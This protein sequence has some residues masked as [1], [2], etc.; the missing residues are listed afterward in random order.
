MTDEG[1]SAPRAWKRESSREVAGYEMFRVREDR[2]VSPKDG[3]TH[4]FQIAESPGGVVVVAETDDGRLVMVQQFRHGTRQVTLELPSGVADDGESPETAA[5]RE[6][7]EETGYE[8]EGAEVLGAVE[9][10]PS[11]QHTCVHV[12]RVRGARATAEKEPDETEEIRVCL[13][14][15]NELRR[16]IVRGEVDTA[17]TVAALA[18]WEWRGLP[19]EGS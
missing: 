7:R 16:R 11:W 15:V 6:L 5:A 13:V 12:V 18:L 3:E 8:G 19:R 17:T 9:L 14:P 2:S 1:D 10:N 4:A